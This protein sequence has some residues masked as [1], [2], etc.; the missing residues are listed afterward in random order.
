MTEITTIQG[1]VQKGKDRGKKLG[2]P[3]INF[4]V[5][6]EVSEGIYLSLIDIKGKSFN[7]LTFIGAAKTFDDTTH[8][9]ETYVLD[10]DH[11][12]YGEYVKVSLIKKIRDNQKFATEQELIAQMEKDKKIAEDFFGNTT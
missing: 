9:A 3:T 2:F 10:F 6:L 4:P 11:D 8:Q 7:A 12:I 1:V 5:A